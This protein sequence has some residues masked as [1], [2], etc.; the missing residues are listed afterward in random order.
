MSRR[1]WQLNP[2]RQ[3]SASAPADVA[4]VGDGVA[5]RRVAMLAA[6]LDLPLAR[7]GGEAFDLLLVVR[8][9]RLELRETKRGAPGPVYVDF[10]SGGPGHGRRCAATRRQPI[11]RAVGL[12]DGLPSI[13]DATAGL[14]RD[15]FVL[16]SLGCKVTAVERSGVLAA[17]LRDGL[18]RASAVPLFDD[19]ISERFELIVADARNVLAGMMGDDAPDV[20][21]LDPM[22]P[23]DAKAS[24]LAKKEM[25]LLRL[26]VGDDHDACE[27][28]DIARKI[29]RRRVVVKR[30]RRAPPLG[31]EP[32]L[33][34]RG[35][36][37]RY[38]VYLS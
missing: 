25:R 3:W 7:D 19:V 30:G 29:A 9:D 28:L 22:F 8:A 14:G 38:D 12:A 5:D 11:A 26:L 2:Q 1:S 31:L 15:A 27:L 17:L 4:V 13:V 18:Q 24:A 23:V 20:V 32:S 35:K 16:A 6:E 21:Y 36:I 37:A 10:V 33:A 34:Y